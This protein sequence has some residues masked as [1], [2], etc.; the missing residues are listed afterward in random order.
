[1]FYLNIVV[2][3]AY[4]RDYL[5]L[6]PY[7]NKYLLNLILLN[8]P[9]LILYITI[10]DTQLYKRMSIETIFLVNKQKKVVNA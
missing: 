7:Y 9:K 1:M 10:R 8:E 3:G 6:K 2:T 4:K 5:L